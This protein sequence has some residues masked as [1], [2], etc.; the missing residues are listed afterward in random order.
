[1]RN[2]EIL[3]K[4]FPWGYWGSFYPVSVLGHSIGKELASHAGEYKLTFHQEVKK[5]PYSEANK[6]LFFTGWGLSAEGKLKPDVTLPGGNGLF[7]D[8]RWFL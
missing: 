8:S 3:F 2:K 7:S 5:V 4:I 1:M 6:M